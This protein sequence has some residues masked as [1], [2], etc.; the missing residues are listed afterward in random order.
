MPKYNK[1]IIADFFGHYVLQVMKYH[2]LVFVVKVTQ[3]R[4]TIATA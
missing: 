4:V 1:N 3:Y 2:G